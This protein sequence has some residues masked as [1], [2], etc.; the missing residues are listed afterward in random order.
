MRC[1]AWID[2]AVRVVERTNF[3]TAIRMKDQVFRHRTMVTTVRGKL[4]RKPIMDTVR[5]KLL[6]LRYMQGR[7]GF[8]PCARKNTVV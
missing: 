2:M 1:P 8:L 6:F 4:I 3:Q 7:S 5:L